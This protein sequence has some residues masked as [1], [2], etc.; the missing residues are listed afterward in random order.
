[1]EFSESFKETE[2]ELY[3]GSFVGHLFEK[4]EQVLSLSD[5][6]S[7]SSDFPGLQLKG[8]LDAKKLL[9][10]ASSSLS[11][12]SAD[13][14]MAGSLLAKLKIEHNQAVS[15]FF[16]KK[17]LAG[18]IA[19]VSAWA[20]YK[21]ANMLLK[22]HSTADLAFYGAALATDASAFAGSLLRISG[23][24][25]GYGAMP[26]ALGLSFRAGL[27]LYNQDYSA[28]LDKGKS[29]KDKVLSNFR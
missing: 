17:G 24:L 22:S 23:G 6:N 2:P 19:A 18:G 8:E 12:L 21:D 7:N 11:N 25:R 15:P 13:E 26:M 29:W 28:F 9:N 4:N 5:R 27:A 20:A 1:M 3:K 16:R 14:I 10:L